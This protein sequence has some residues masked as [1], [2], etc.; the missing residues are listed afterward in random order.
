MPVK[1]STKSPHLLCKSYLYIRIEIY[2]FCRKKNG[3]LDE[4]F[5]TGFHVSR[6]IIF[7]RGFRLMFRHEGKGKVALCLT[8]HHDMKTCCGVVV[9]LHAFFGLGTRWR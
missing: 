7:Q 9:E 8:K 6:S 2:I 5:E 4:N 1:N 3:L